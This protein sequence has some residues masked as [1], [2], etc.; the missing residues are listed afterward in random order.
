MTLLTSICRACFMVGFPW[1]FFHV[2]MIGCCTGL[3]HSVCAVA[4]IDAYAARGIVAR[5]AAI[6]TK[7][8][9]CAVRHL[10][11]H[12]GFRRAARV[13]GIEQTPASTP[14][15]LAKVSVRSELLFDAAITAKV[16]AALFQALDVKGLDVTMETYKA[17][18]EHARQRWHGAW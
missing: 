2:A 18:V 5:R 6:R 4:H 10:P 8:R 16:K 7:L 11:L 14:G 15:S 13:W 1:L 12:P 17:V 3:A 9:R